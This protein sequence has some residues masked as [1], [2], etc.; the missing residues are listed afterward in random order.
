MT[1]CG[2]AIARGVETSLF[3]YVTGRPTLGD[4]GRY[5]IDRSRVAFERSVAEDE[6]DLDSGFLIAP[7]AL[8]EQPSQTGLASSIAGGVD[9]ENRGS[10]VE[11]VREAAGSSGEST[12]AATTEERAVTVSFTANRE[13][14]FNA[15]NALANLADLAGKVS[16]SARAEGTLDKGKLENGVLEPLRELG[17]IDD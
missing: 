11:M 5:Q 12:T 15:W 4:D 9:D 16:V 3:G 7:K 8:P 10:G 6:I 1:S 2:K 17:L 14:L 13:A